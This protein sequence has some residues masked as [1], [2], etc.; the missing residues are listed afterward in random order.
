VEGAV[1][2]L[3]GV[4][5]VDGDEIGHRY[6]GRLPA[7]GFVDVAVEPIDMTVGARGCSDF[8]SSTD[9]DVTTGVT[10]DFNEARNLQVM[11]GVFAAL[12]E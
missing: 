4:V 5:E 8:V 9:A 10:R 2:V 7:A 12:A 3:E 1:W 6:M 11:R